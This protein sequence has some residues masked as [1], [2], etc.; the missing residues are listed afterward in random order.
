MSSSRWKRFAFFDRSALPL[1]SAVLE[2][3]FF[4]ASSSAAAA[5][6]DDAGKKTSSSTAEGRGRADRS[7]KAKRFHREELMV[8]TSRSNGSTGSKDTQWEHKM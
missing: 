8:G 4:P 7:K 3:V 5:A 1:P 6:L 2:E